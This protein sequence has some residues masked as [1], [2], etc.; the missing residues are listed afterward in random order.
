MGWIYEKA[1]GGCNA[2]S[3]ASGGA[4]GSGAMVCIRDETELNRTGRDGTGRDG[5]EREQRCHRMETRRKKKETE[6]L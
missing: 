2:T 5:T 4:R 1:M 6:R 3:I